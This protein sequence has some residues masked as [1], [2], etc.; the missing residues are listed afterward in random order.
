[1]KKRSEFVNTAADWNPDDEVVEVY[2]TGKL[3][4]KEFGERYGL[5]VHDLYSNPS[6]PNM[7]IGFAS[8]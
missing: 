1:M 3:S 2:E 7:Q 5:V 8:K 6:N 4:V